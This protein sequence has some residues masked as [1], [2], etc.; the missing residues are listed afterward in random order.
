MIHLINNS[1]ANKVGQV[2]KNFGVIQ[3]RVDKK[4][5]LTANIMAL[6]VEN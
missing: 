3:T 5:V 2:E 1:M 6:T 4:S